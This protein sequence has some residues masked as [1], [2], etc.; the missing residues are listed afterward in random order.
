MKPGSPITIDGINRHKDG[1]TFP[2]EAR[3]GVFELNGELSVIGLVRDVSSQVAAEEALRS[4]EEKYRSIFENAVEGIY[5]TTHDGEYLSANPA[6]A[7]IYGYDSADDLMFSIDDIA[8][9]IYVDPRR[10][11]D[12]VDLMDTCGTI[13]GFDKQV[14]SKCVR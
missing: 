2:I 13:S 7:H 5:Q 11:Q 14:V 6:L 9:E 12:F 3:V 10:H 4:T 8:K 1:N